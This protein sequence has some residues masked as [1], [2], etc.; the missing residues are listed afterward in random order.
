MALSLGLDVRSYRQSQRARW[1]AALLASSALIAAPAAAQDATWAGPGANWNSTAN[2]TP[3][4][5]PTGTAI[6]A[7]ALP[8]SLTFSAATTGIGTIQ[9]NAGAPAYTFTLSAGQTLT[10][11]GSGIVNNSANAPTVS[12]FNSTIN[13][14]NGSTAANT[15]FNLLSSALNFLNSSNAGTANIAMPND[16]LPGAVTFKNT[17]SAANATIPH[18][19]GITILGGGVFFMDAS[20]AG[21]AT[22]VNDPSGSV[23]GE[24][25][26]LIFGDPQFLT[27]PHT[28][29]AGTAHITNNQFG[30]TNFLSQTSAANATI[31]NN[32][33]GFTVFQQ[34]STAANATITTNSG[35]G[36]FFFDQSTGGAARFITNAGATFDMSGLDTAGMTAGSIE[37]AGQYLLG[38]KRLTVGSNNLSTTVSGTIN[39]GGGSGGVGGSLVKVGTGTLILS[40][41]NGYT[42][43]TTISGGTVQVTNGS[44]VGTGAVTLDGG[45]FKS[46]AANLSFTNNFVVNGTGGTIDNSNKK[47][48]LSGVISNGSGSP[49]QLKLIGG[50]GGTTV[51]SG[52]NT[53]TGG[54]LVSGTAVQVKSNSAL[55]TGTVTLDQALLQSGAANLTIGNAFAINDTPAGSAIDNN[56][57]KFTLSGNIADGNGPGKL[58][59]VNSGGNGMTVLTGVS[60][61]TGGTEICNCATVQ[62]GDATHTA[63]L[64]GKILNEGE[65]DIVNA[66]TTAITK[67]VNKLGGFTSFANTTSAGTAKIVNKNGGMTEFDNHSTAGNAKI[68]NKNGGATGFANH[69]SAD[70][71]KIVTKHFSALFFLDNSTAGDATLIT[72]QHGLVLFGDKS[73]GGNAQFITNGTGVVDFSGSSGPGNDGKITAGS[74]AGSGSYFIGAGNTLIVGGNNL[75]SEVSG[76]IADACGCSPGPGSLTKVGT[77]TLTLSGVN[78]YTGATTVNGGTLS[79]NGSIA[80]SSGVTVNAGGTVGGTGNLPKTTI[81][82]GALSPGNSIGTINISGSLSF[83]GAGNYIVEVSPSAADKT[84]V[85][86]APGTAALAGT[87]SAIGTGGNYTI[88]TKYTIINASGGVSGTF[89]SIAISGNFGVTKPHIEYD[90]NNVYLVLDPNAL[91]LTGLTPNERAVAAAVNTAIMAGSQSAPFLALFNLTAAQLPGA[92]D[93]L[94]G[95][96]HA[97]T[98][99]VLLDESLY[100]R[101]AVLGR[102]RQASYGGADGMAA[103]SLGG[104]QAFAGDEELSAL[105]YGKSPIVTKAPPM[106]SRPGYDVTFWAQGFGAWGKFD[107]DGNAAAVRRNLAGFFSGVDTRVGANGRL[108]VMTGYTASSNTLDGRGNANVE[109]GHLAGYGGWSFGAFNL[110]GGAA[111]AWHTVDTNRTAAF[112]GFFDSLTA[113][114]EGR[115]GQIFG[116]AGYG[117][118]FGKVAVEPFAGAA[119]VHL[120]TDA[121][122]E[123][124]GAAALRVAASAFEVGYS[125]LGIRAASVIPLS[126]DMVLVPRVSV[127]WQHAF[128]DVTPD[129]RLAF[130]AAPVPFVIAGVPLARDSLLSEAGLDLAIGRH[131]TVGLSYVGQL[132]RNVHDHAAKGKFTWKF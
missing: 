132:A 11:S 4:S 64:A 82:G 117:F 120:Q 85:T 78:T 127:A 26:L 17:A 49:A 19:V 44:S 129:A 93:Q 73:T 123:R 79:V 65:F 76:V 110:R 54:T 36:V 68:V 42:G 1:R 2:W 87:L 16:F 40:G 86:G 113:H 69:S 33:G 7:G 99:G 34:Q 37:G 94:S 32:N 122:N 75:S 101:S 66:D 8:T 131:A 39:D 107:G 100:P 28:S 24:G 77:G 21:N 104:P 6:F 126:W 91:P 97:S 125:T 121:T 41:A 48:T 18:N 12:T 124:G 56:N 20:T 22:I 111:A 5:V 47:L 103:L 57:R 88:G 13:F 60:S 71:A 98:A 50:M 43:G 59:F 130:I 105:A 109:T 67:I 83:V 115:T 27:G 96:L 61:Y 62:L 52:A 108:G 63:A 80:S 92:L 84:N 90:A 10:A 14:Q 81:N 128:E 55:G 9:F 106:V 74:I 30:A 89:G 72:K 38:S 45:I 23:A 31:V 29:N 95:E 102:L 35:G 112:P 25:G 3:A 58:T 51:L 70:N 119:W 46:G 116:E 53:Y 114:Y 15:T 118:A